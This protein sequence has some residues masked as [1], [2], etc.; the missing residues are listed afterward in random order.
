MD[1]EQNNFQTIFFDTLDKERWFKIIS[2]VRRDYNEKAFSKQILI[3]FAANLNSANLEPIHLVTLAC[4]I[5]FFIDQQHKVY[6]S[7]QND[8]IRNILLNELRFQEYWSG[9]KNHVDS[10]SQNYFNLWRIVEAEKD[11][12]AKNVEEYFRNTFF[13]G[14]DLSAISLSMVEA[15]YIM[16]LIMPKQM[17]MLFL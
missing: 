4:L 12:Y 9:G 15:Y 7:S 5:Q 14:K 13:K 17:V 6:L 2:S 3:K 10:T 11:L 1:S 8:S 16:Y